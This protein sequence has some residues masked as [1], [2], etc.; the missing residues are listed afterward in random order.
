MSREQR[1]GPEYAYRMRTRFREKKKPAQKPQ[2]PVI[3]TEYCVHCENAPLS[4]EVNYCEYCGE[5]I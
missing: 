3:E 5:M 4:E 2:S 1:M